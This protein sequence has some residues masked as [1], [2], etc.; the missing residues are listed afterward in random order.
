MG[1]L[2][3]TIHGKK[4]SRIPFWYMRQAGR[5]LPEYRELRAQQADFFST[6]FNAE[7]AAE[8]TLQPI[9]RYDMDA[10]IIFSDILV[11]PLAMGVDIRFET[12]EGPIVDP[13]TRHSVNT[14]GTPREDILSPVCDALSRVRKELSPDKDLIG[15][16]GAPWTILCYLYG[17]KRHNEFEPARQAIYLHQT[18]FFQLLENITD[19]T[20]QY[21]IRQI[22]SGANIVMLFDSWA[23]VA[24]SALFD[25][26]LVE[27]AKRITSIIKQKYPHVPVIGFPRGISGRHAEFVEK[28]GV[29]VL[30]IDQFTDMKTVSD[31]MTKQVTLQGNLDPLTMLSTEQQILE[32][33]E[34]ILRSMQGR[35]HIFNLGHG[36]I[37]QIPPE[38]V[39]TLSQFL[40]EWRHDS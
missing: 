2:L 18:E 22:E 12:G 30:S 39:A 14:I 36:M 9:R 20:A 19:A 17:G 27:P 34:H 32:Q 7:V 29:D 1:L 8:I 33:A 40:R 31:T 23:A 37:P 15:F 26:L 35:P 5:Y 10:A 38:H 21:L 13:S 11:L 24:P 4:P 16:A 6:C 3:D 28:T 25:T